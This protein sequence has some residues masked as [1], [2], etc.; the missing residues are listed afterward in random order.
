MTVRQVAICLLLGFP[1][2]GYALVALTIGLAT[3]AATL[4]GRVATA[5]E[6]LNLL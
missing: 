2:L 4:S 1:E 3:A 5:L 6:Q